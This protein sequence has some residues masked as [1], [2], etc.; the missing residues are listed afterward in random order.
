MSFSERSS[1]HIESENNFAFTQSASCKYN[2][3]IWEISKSKIIS[4]AFVLVYSIRKINI[5]IWY[6]NCYWEIIFFI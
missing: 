1:Q 4:G 2:L 5:I 6:Q 3:E